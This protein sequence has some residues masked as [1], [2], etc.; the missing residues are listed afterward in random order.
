MP[1]AYETYIASV[2]DLPID[3]IGGWKERVGP[4][5]I[6]HDGNIAFAYV[7]S[8]ALD[9]KRFAIGY[10][11]LG[12]NERTTKIIEVKHHTPQFARRYYH[13]EGHFDLLVPEGHNEIYVVQEF[14]EEEP[15]QFGGNY[16]HD[17]VPGEIMTHVRESVQ[18][19]EH[20]HD[21]EKEA[22]MATAEY[23]LFFELNIEG[24]TAGACPLY[25]LLNGTRFLGMGERVR[26]TQGHYRPI[27]GKLE[28]TN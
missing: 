8:R 21:K 23:A 14:N 24:R 20:V 26:F 2:D 5:S 13:S 7:H 3:D 4:H 6:G 17:D 9:L 19:G 18:W 28:A 1:S 12:D 16:T 22:L 10:K 27:S 25:L 11:P 15:I